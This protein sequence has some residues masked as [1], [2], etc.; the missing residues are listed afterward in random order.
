MLNFTRLA[1][2]AFGDNENSYRVYYQDSEGII[3]QSCYD[4]SNGWYIID[5]GVVANSAKI[6]TPIAV[7]TWAD[8]KEMRVYYMSKDS[9]SR[10]VERKWTVRNSNDLGI[11]EDGADLKSTNPEPRTQLAVACAETDNGN[12]RV[13][14]F[15]QSTNKEL[16]QTSYD[17]E[18]NEWQDVALNSGNGTI[19]AP[20][21]SS[22]AATAT[23]TTR[24]FFQAENSTIEMLKESGRTW[25]PSELM[26]FRPGEKRP[27]EKKISQYSVESKLT[28]GIPMTRPGNRPMPG[29][30]LP[31]QQIIDE[32]QPFFGLSEEQ[33]VRLL[34]SR[35]LPVRHANADGRGLSSDSGPV[36]NALFYLVR[37][38]HY[39]N[40]YFDRT[41]GSGMGA[42]S[43]RTNE[44][45]AVGWLKRIELV[46]DFQNDNLSL[47]LFDK[48]RFAYV[49]YVDQRLGRQLDISKSW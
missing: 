13:Q 35:G 39:M 45:D 11:W 24:V 5:D 43:Y 28:L 8:G 46:A 44:V 3:R 41:G 2:V 22:L 12:I 23:G 37:G 7:A 49:F 34:A 21:G 14:L 19:K 25:K 10:L 1:A 47:M 20:R 17:S 29:A 16:R 36:Y 40:K 9:P 42:T 15:Y 31:G 30:V 27:S 48:D 38:L 6:E 26:V 4:E 32:S 18:K 33:F